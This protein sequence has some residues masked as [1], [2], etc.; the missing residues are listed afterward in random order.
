MI[1]NIKQTASSEREKK[2]NILLDLLSLKKQIK[3]TGSFKNIKDFAK[4]IFSNPD[5]TL[6]AKFCFQQWGLNNLATTEG[7]KFLKKYA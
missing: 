2:I 6:F 7:M 1:V 3:Q 5:K 4:D